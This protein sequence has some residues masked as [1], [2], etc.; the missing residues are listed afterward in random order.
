MMARESSC[1]DSVGEADR[2]SHEP[3]FLHLLFKVIGCGEL[4][5]RLLME[6][7]HTRGRRHSGHQRC[8]VRVG[9]GRAGG[10]SEWERMGALSGTAKQAI[11]LCRE[12][13][14]SS[15][16][17]VRWAVLAIGRTVKDPR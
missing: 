7:S 15:S 10:G 4:P 2:Q 11:P 5:Q 1:R 16:R 6:I 13:E 9:Q 3:T 14:T 17:L 12:R 8:S